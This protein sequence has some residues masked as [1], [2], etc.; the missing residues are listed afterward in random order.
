MKALPL[1]IA[2]YLVFAVMAS[3]EGEL[4]LTKTIFLPK[5]EG[6]IDHL[7]IDEKGDRLFVAALGNNTLEVIDL[8]SGSRTES[9]SGL[10]KPQ[11]VLYL[12][13]QNRIYVASGEE[14]TLKAFSGST[15]K[16]LSSIDKL[17]DAD[18]V[19]FD[20]RA[21]LVYVGYGDGALA[22]VDPARDKLVGSIKLDAHP[23]SF[24]LEQKGNRVYVNIPEA[25]QIAVVDRERKEVVARWPMDKFKSNFPMALDE[26]NHRLFVGCRNPARLVVLDTVTGKLVAD[27]EI[28]GDTDDLF[29]DAL[30]KRVYIA[31]GEGVIDTVAQLG[32]DDYKL[33]SKTRTAPGARTGFYS[34]TRGEFFL[35]V[36]HRG[37]QATRIQVYE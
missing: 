13:G 37:K 36:P 34:A 1:L 2:V 22:V 31:C 20:P 4:T 16:L 27:M 17:D 5:V 14:G 29:Y 6:R 7:A 26:P 21:N 9:V 32:P 28:G 19:R 8:K 12:A 11:G 18:N 15:Y 23:E 25:R 10:R 24:Q 33:S 3:A 35:A 30:N